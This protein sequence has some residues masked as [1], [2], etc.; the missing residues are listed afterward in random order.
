MVLHLM[1]KTERQNH[2]YKCSLSYIWSIRCEIQKGA[3]FDK[4]VFYGDVHPNT[5]KCPNCRSRRVTRFGRHKPRTFK[6]L[7]V[8]RRKIELVVN[9]PRLYCKDCG[10]IRQPHLA[11]ADPK[12]HYTRSL[13]RFVIDLCRVSAPL[14]SKDAWLFIS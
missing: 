13:E 12:K 1:E 7:P 8:G 2:V 4:T 9:I 14:Y 5:L 6:M 3:F 10:T 11:F